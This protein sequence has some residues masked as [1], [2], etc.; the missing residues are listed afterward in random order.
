MPSPAT[1]HPLSP[2]SL[3]ASGVMSQ[4]RTENF[5]VAS[6]V[7]PRAVRSHLLAIYGFARLVDDIGDEA[8]G[9]RLAQLDWAELELQ[10]AALGTA[11]HPVFVALVP[12]IARFDL[13]LDP[14]RALIAANRQDRHG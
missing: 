12:T 8:E 9:D 1:G 14:F 4:A 13:S 7:L 2:P 5:P 6:L 10:R 11:E 3:S